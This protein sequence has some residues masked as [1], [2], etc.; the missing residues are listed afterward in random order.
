MDG[1]G[2]FVLRQQTFLV[3]KLRS[4]SSDGHPSFRLPFKETFPS[5]SVQRR[6]IN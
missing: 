5:L 2:D 6:S 1:Q 4:F 3:E